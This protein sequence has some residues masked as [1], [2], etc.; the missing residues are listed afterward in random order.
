VPAGR[1]NERDVPGSTIT[2]CCTV[3]VTGAMTV[4]WFS[5]KCDQR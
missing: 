5:E 4:T 1:W 2:N 3:W